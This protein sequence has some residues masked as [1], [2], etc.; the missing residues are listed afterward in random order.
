MKISNVILTVTSLEKS[1]AF[2]R[3][4]VGLKLADRRGE[5]GR[6]EAGNV[7]LIIR[8]SGRQPE[9]GN[10]EVVLEVP[11]IHATYELLKSRGA[12]FSRAPRPVT[13]DGTRDLYATDFRDPDG[14]ILSIT[15][16]IK[17][18]KQVVRA[19]P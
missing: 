11:D 5:F 2:Y 1:L 4:T 17:K 18:P 7:M 14:H 12:V 16:W 3:D 19:D 15:S 9:P 13:G 8:E 6:F 10:T